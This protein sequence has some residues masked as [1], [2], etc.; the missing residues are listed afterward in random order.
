MCL[1]KFCCVLNINNSATIWVFTLQLQFLFICSIVEYVNSSLTHWKI[2][3][4]EQLS[5]DNYLFWGK[6]C[7]LL[8]VATPKWMKTHRNNEFCSIRIKTVVR[9]EN[10]VADIRIVLTK[11]LIFQ[12]FVAQE[13]FHI[14]IETFCSNDLEFCAVLTIIGRKRVT[15]MKFWL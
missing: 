15:E 5:T 3:D 9:G 10:G 1:C 14:P 7:P 13:S 2:R 4:S 6:K 12:F 11:E 8:Q